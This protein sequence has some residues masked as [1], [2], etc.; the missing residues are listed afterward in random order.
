VSILPTIFSD[1]EQDF[2]RNSSNPIEA[3]FLLWTR[4]ES[5]LKASG[6]GITDNLVNVPSL[7][8]VHLAELQG[9]I[10]A[11][12]EVVSFQANAEVWLS[13]C[14]AKGMQIKLHH[15]KPEHIG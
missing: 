2:V 15:L 1:L 4:K 12:Q 6:I 3:F 8:G 5:L 9:T 13:V 11:E 10:H 7:N 14:F